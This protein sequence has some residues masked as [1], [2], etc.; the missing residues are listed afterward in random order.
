VVV[1]RRYL[2]VANQS[3]PGPELRDELHRR[4]EAGACAFY[5]LVPNT[6]AVNYPDPSAITAAALQP[7]MTWWITDYR[8]PSTDE[9]ASEQARRRLDQILAELA[10]SGVPAEGEI[11]G[12]QPLEAMEKLFT[13]HQ[14]DEIII[15]TLPQPVSR[16]LRA[17]LPRK[18]ER[19]F[20]LP[21][22]TIITKR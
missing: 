2:V 9:E 22:T 6:A 20:G 4:I 13:D 18:A 12:S 5:L 21:V 17:D 1:V 10:V 3:L 14:F 15:A 7:A 19:R 11:G 16:W 8:R